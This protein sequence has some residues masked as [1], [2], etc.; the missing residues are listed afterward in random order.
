[1]L[2][3]GFVSFVGTA[4]NCRQSPRRGY[5]YLNDSVRVEGGKGRARAG[6]LYGRGRQYVVAA[7]GCRRTK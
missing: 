1:M 6:A 3:C 4:P 7:G 2:Y 5:H